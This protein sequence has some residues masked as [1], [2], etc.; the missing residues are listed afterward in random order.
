MG[1]CPNCGFKPEPVCT[2]VNGQGEL[3]ELN[4]EDVLRINLKKK[5]KKETANWTMA[6]KAKFFAEL[7]AYGIQKGRK[8]GWA[9]HS[10][11]EKFG[12]WPDRSFSDCDPAPYPSSSTVM[13]CHS[14]AIAW[15]KSKK[16]QET[17]A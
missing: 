2:I 4:G 13:W 16:K 15:A 6:E 1:G 3:A 12:V 7:K 14:R 9:A 8:N 17:H 5:R 11:K 10:Y